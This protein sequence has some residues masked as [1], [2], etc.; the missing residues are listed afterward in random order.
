M[1]RRFIVLIALMGTLLFTSVVLLPQT[2]YAA[3]DAR[4]DKSRS[5]LSVPTWYK[6]LEVKYDAKTQGCDIFIPRDTRGQIIFDKVTTPILLAI[7]EILLFIGSLLAIGY[8]IWGGFQ[9]QL[10]QGEPDK[11]KNA[12]LII[13]NAI[14]G[15]VIMTLSAGIVNLIARNIT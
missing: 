15:L 1:M 4:C 10:S 13:I 2:S 5:F 9:Y 7:F 12:R 8:I 6:Y 3:V 14:A 11:A